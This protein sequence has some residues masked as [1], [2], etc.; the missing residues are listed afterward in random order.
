MQIAERFINAP[1]CAV[2]NIV[3]SLLGKLTGLINSGVQAIMAPLNAILGTVDIAGDII[4]FVEDIISFLSCQDQ[5]ECPEVTGWSIW[6][7]PTRFTS[8]SN[9]NPLSIVN[10]VKTYAST[11]QQ[12]VDPEN[13][14]FDLDFSDIFEDTCNVG[15]I[16]CGPPTVEFYGGG[17]SG[18][19]GNVIVNAV[20][21][22]LAVDLTSFGSGYTS[23]PV[24]RF[25]D[26]CGTGRGA[27]GR[28]IIGPVAG[29]G[30][31]IGV[32]QVIID[33]NGSGYLQTPNGDRGGDGRVWAYA[34]QTTVKRA[35]GK[36]DRPYYP[37]EIINVNPGDE[38]YSCG[39]NSVI[40]QGQAYTA[41]QCSQQ[42]LPKQDKY[43]TS[44]ELDDVTIENPGV[45]YNCS[46]DKIKITP[47]R[48]AILEYECDSYGSIT[49]VKVVK[50]GIG[51]TEEPMIE[52]ETETGY[53]ARFRPVFRVNSIG[54]VIDPNQVI[55][56]IDCVGKV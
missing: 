15:P 38:V 10:K 44:L 34:D 49:K 18:A 32:V 12:S 9:S 16:F 33:N 50:R 25:V 14:D 20:G 43:L 1:L 21:D 3:G 24:V 26:A 42:I 27:T 39:R 30:T 2:E 8:S 40:T 45:N 46:I 53:N 19:A 56:V 35:D 54:E 51:F 37:G 41:P 23:A 11:V 28:S 55:S 47:D 13:F 4:G 5:P 48:G 29:I 22:I 7:G 36:Y 17:G 31:T 52:I 6:N